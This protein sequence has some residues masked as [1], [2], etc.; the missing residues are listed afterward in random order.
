MQQIQLQDLSMQVMKQTENLGS[1]GR[2]ANNKS[3]SER[4]FLS[5]PIETFSKPLE[6]QTWRIHALESPAYK[7]STWRRQR[8]EGQVLTEI[9]VNRIMKPEGKQKSHRKEGKIRTAY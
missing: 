6:L 3:R 4:N 5:F 1:G 8:S 2:L 9:T 7:M